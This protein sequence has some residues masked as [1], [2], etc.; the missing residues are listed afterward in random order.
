MK[1][2]L[3]YFYLGSNENKREAK[4]VDVAGAEITIHF[5]GLSLTEKP[6]RKVYHLSISVAPNTFI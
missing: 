6:D 2:V 5:P 4:S 3:Y 1:R